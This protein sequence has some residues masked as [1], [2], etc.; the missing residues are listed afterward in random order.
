MARNLTTRTVETT[1]AGDVRREIPD[2]LLP[3][4]YLICQPSGH[5]SWCVRY[6]HAGLPRKHTLGSWPTIDLAEA[7]DLGRKALIEAKRGKDPRD[8]K[9]VARQVA[10]A[11]E[12][13][14]VATIVAEFIERYAKVNTRSWKS[15]E[16]ILQKHV[17]P[18]WQGRAVQ[19]I[20]KRDVLDVLDVIVARGKP[21]M[22][23]RVL[24]HT[25]KLFSWCV[26]RDIL[27]ISPCTGIKAPA[28]EGKRERALDDRELKIV[29]RA[30]RKVG[31]PFGALVEL[32]ALTGARLREASNMTWEEVKFDEKLWRIPANRTKNK[33]QHEIPL[34]DQ[35]IAILRSTPRIYGKAGYVFTLTGTAPIASFSWNRQKLDK[36]CVEPV[37]PW[38]L[39]DLRRV[40]ATGLARLGVNLPVI[41]RCLNHASGSF[42]GIVAVYQ[43]HKFA[44]E[45]RDAF[46][47]WGDHVEQLI[48]APRRAR[49]G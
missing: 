3:G 12:R 39:H 47:R 19:T 36:A 21:I 8:A 31:W 22:A 9:I 23:N 10:R 29:L 17:L 38:V 4:L 6:R 18:C 41:E 5:K 34:S 48:T 42:A 35:A 37:A 14:D 1:K 40:F 24:S 49:R 46:Q 20:T 2:G 44:D 30:A 32:L 11:A 15:T 16:K 27:T 45:M 28:P 33:R 7:R 43:K 26:D 13:D 25:R